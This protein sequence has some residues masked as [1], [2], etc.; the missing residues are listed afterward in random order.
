MQREEE[1]GIQ[2]KERG[3]EIRRQSSA[4][5]KLNLYLKNQIKFLY[6]PFHE[7]ERSQLST[8]VAS[9]PP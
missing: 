3:R 5:D 1:E 6:T 4:A 8:D 9:T 7:T 2:E